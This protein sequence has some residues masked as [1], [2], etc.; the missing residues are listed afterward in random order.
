MSTKP[1]TDTNTAAVNAKMSANQKKNPVPAATVSVKEESKRPETPIRRPSTPVKSVENPRK[2]VEATI[3]RPE[4]PTGS[5]NNQ[6]VTKVHHTPS[7]SVER[8]VERSIEPTPERK[9]PERRSVEKPVETTKS[10]KL[11]ALRKRSKAAMETSLAS[12]MSKLGLLDTTKADEWRTTG[13]H[14]LGAVKTESNAI[15][16]T[17]RNIDAEQ[18]EPEW[19]D[20]QLRYINKAKSTILNIVAITETRRSAV[21]A[22]MKYVGRDAQTGSIIP[23]KD[24]RERSWWREF[25]FNRVRR[26]SRALWEGGR[27]GGP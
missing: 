27:R 14:A 22:E 15:T 17:G 12:S 6:P 10:S 19:D 8:V 20:E 18:T 1:N 13:M 21:D 11:D 4:T 2:T 23:T 3:K 7:R 24:H 9:T 5:A 25:R 16:I 26:G